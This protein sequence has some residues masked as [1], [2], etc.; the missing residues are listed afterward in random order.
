MSPLIYLAFAVVL[1]GFFLYR[2]LELKMRS[3][4]RLPMRTFTF[5]IKYLALLFVGLLIDHYFMIR[6]E[7]WG[8]GL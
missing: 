6:L 2:A 3:D 1:G 7:T 4:A 5:S 8:V